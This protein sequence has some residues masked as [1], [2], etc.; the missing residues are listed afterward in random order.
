LTDLETTRDEERREK[1]IR[2]RKEK[3]LKGKL[4]KKPFR[5]P[6]LKEKLTKELNKKTQV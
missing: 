3:A 2:E 4:A 1:S 5:P 6:K